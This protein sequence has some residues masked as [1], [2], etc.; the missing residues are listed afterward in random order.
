M[1]LSMPRKKAVKKQKVEESVD[2]ELEIVEPEME[3]LKEVEAEDQVEKQEQTIDIPSTFDI[4]SREGVSVNGVKFSKGTYKVG[5]LVGTAII[6][7]H[8]ANCL[9]SLDIQSIR[10]N[11][12]SA[13]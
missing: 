3:K 6:T 9:V 7:Q 12:S 5:Q 4:K 8:L 11:P 13:L 10:S 2:M 1:E